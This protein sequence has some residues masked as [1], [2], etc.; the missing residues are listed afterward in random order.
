MLDHVGRNEMAAGTG[1]TRGLLPEG[2]FDIYCPLFGGDPSRPNYLSKSCRTRQAARACTDRTCPRRCGAPQRQHR[3]RAP[4][5][6]AVADTVQK[7][8]AKPR[9]KRR[10]ATVGKSA[11]ACKPVFDQQALNARG[12]IVVTV[13]IPDAQAHLYQ[14]LAN[15]ARR[16][17]R[18]LAAE[19]LA[20]L[21]LRLKQ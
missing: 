20:R 10:K 17:N 16:K 18:S 9:P 4:D 12:G 3:M 7:P 21:A 1:E 13:V 19:I 8:A 2:E 6:P 14:V 15:A 11:P 5:K